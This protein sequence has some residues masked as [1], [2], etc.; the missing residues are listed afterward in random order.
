M[1]VRVKLFLRYIICNWATE[2]VTEA[3]MMHLRFAKRISATAALGDVNPSWCTLYLGNV[4]HFNR[5][6]C[7]HVTG[8]VL[9][10][11]GD[12]GYSAGRV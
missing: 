8:V 10:P 12:C 1:D 7:L 2:S 11:L 5:N 3:P 9:E 4:E 6:S